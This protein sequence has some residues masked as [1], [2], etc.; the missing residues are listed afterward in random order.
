MP[1]ENPLDDSVQNEQPLF[2]FKT[3]ELKFKKKFYGQNGS[4]TDRN[5]MKIEELD[6]KYEDWMKNYLK[7]KNGLIEFT[8]PKTGRYQII[9][10]SR[11]VNEDTDS[12]RGPSMGVTVELYVDFKKVSNPY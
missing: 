12:V 3:I 1:I 2:D 4:V 7:M 10:Q 5:K 8:V 9:Q 6:I 11:S